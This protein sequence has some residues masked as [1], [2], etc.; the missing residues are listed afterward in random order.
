[1]FFAHSTDRKDKAD[2]QPLQNRLAAVAALASERKCIKEKSLLKRHDQ[3]PQVTAHTE[4]SICYATAQ[5][6]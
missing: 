3:P 6:K 2:W 4:Q 1:M 5:A